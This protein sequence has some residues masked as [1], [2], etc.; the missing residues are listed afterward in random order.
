MNKKLIATGSAKH[1][2]VAPVHPHSLGDVTSPSRFCSNLDFGPIWPKTKRHDPSTTALSICSDDSSFTC[3][4]V[5][6]QT[7]KQSYKHM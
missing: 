5:N 3:Y 4:L 1:D 6:K 2:I 7:N